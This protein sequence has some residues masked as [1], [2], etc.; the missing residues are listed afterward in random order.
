MAA[1][2]RLLAR[3][4]C[5]PLRTKGIFDYATGKWAPAKFQNYLTGE[6][7]SG[8]LSTDATVPVGTWDPVLGR[9]YVQ[10]ARQGWG[11]Q[12]S[13]YGGA[14]P[15]L[16][17]PDSGE[18]HLWAVTPAA[19]T[20]ESYNGRSFS[21]GLFD[22]PKVQIDTS[23]EGLARLAGNAPPAWLSD[24]LKQIEAGVS[25]VAS[26]CRNQQDVAG[27]RS[28]AA[29]YRE[30]LDLYA[31]TG[32]SDL[33]AEA[34]SDLQFEL[35]K[36]IDEFQTALKDLLGLDMI[37]FRTNGGGGDPFH[38][39]AADE[40]PRA[41]T[42]GEAFDVRVHTAQANE[43]A[44]LA[45]VWL[46]SQ[47]GSE[48]KSQTSSGSATPEA[49]MRAGDTTFSVTVP[50]DA[51]PTKPY[52][53]QPNT[54][55]PYY[56]ISNP[57]W[58]ERSF[59]PWPLEAWAEFTFDG[60]PIRV[61]GVVETLQH[62]TGVGGFYEPLAVTPAVGVRVEPESRILP[63]DGSPLPVRVTVE[64]E[65]AAEGTIRLKLPDGWT[66]TPSEAHFATNAA[67]ETEPIVFSV[68][69]DE[70]GFGAYTIEAE[71]ES[72]GHIYKSGWHNVSYP[73]LLP[74][75]QY[76]PA[77]LK[78]RKVDVKVAP[79]LH[80]GYV[81]GTGDTVPEAIE[82]LG[83]SRHLLTAADLAAGD[84]SQWNTI[85]IGIR[86]YTTR[87]DLAAAQPRLD[88]FVRNGGTLVVQYQSATFP[89]PLPLAMG[90]TPERVVN[91]DA[92]VKIL[93]PAN[94]LL[95]WPNSITSEDFNGWDEE[96]GHSFLDSWDPSYTALTET[97]DPGQNPQRG[98]LLVAHPGKG[99]YIYVA[100]ALYRQFPEL[101][102]GAY[103]ILANLISAGHEEHQ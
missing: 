58:R 37:A 49:A 62:A 83:V 69:T 77:V 101:V 16:D 84:L 53:T 94:P 88:E 46:V 86:A 27:A 5:A 10:I 57:A 1:A 60:V 72:A 18:Y 41:V 22:N 19:A 68:T 38:G 44:Q 65:A 15:A 61:G 42:P 20:P 95:S 80:V 92:P 12:K 103:R 85:V 13:Q 34:K 21:G 56:D 74:Y 55:Q 78:T 4:L 67:G 90:R 28:L 9:T 73:G 75:N 8:P 50:E 43:A 30:T 99:T 87:P 47:S 36:K 59:A 98:G 7:T 6:W 23:L 32:E 45:H 63:L 89:A 54:E 81:M 97:A 70:A 26:D 76:K 24:G 39:Q 71:A 79:G 100:Y 29:V 51:Q 40:T 31:K 64:T 102:P 2:G 14:S 82:Q 48:W 3:A 25:A 91:E 35:G 33:S 17:E 66:A 11:E 93:D 52:F 96:R